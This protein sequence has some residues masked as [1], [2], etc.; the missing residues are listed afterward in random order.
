MKKLL[1]LLLIL[2]T[3]YLYGQDRITGELFAT[4]S[5]VIAQNGMVA[6]SHPLASQ[7]GI[8]ILKDCLLY[9][10]PSPRDPTKSRMPSSA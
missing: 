2:N 5:E 8:D 6:T 3:I 9:T 1:F 4:R 7:I 10:S